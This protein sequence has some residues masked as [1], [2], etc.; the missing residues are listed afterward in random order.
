MRGWLLSSLLI[1]GCCFGQ[2]RS[3]LES[4]AKGWKDIMPPASLKGWTRISIPPTAPLNPEQQWKLDAAAKTLVCEG[5]KG[6]D[7]L[8]FDTEYS[9][10]IFHAEFKFTKLADETGKR[11]NSGI[12]ARNNADGSIWHQAQIGSS[13]GGYFFGFTPQNGEAK[14]ANLLDKTKPSLVKPAGEWNTVEIRAQGKKMTLWVNGEVTG[15]WDNLEVQKGHV[16][17]EGEGYRIEFRNLKI[18]TL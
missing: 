18:K 5:D 6:H 9:D 17:L 15:E 8:R 16:G 2:T 10:F 1:A 13:S 4:D 3:A 14:R 12:F 7:W 11:Y